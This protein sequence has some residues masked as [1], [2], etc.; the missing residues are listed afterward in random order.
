MTIKDKFP[1]VMIKELLD[2][3]RGAS[4]F[5]KLDMCSGYHQ[6]RMHPDD[7]DKTAFRTHPGLFEFLLYLIYNVLQ[8]QDPQLCVKKSRCEFGLMAL[9]YLGHIISAQGVAMDQLKVQAVLDW[10]QPSS[11]S[12]LRGFLSLACFNRRFIH[13]FGAIVAPLTALKDGFCWSEAAS[14]HSRLPSQHLWYCSS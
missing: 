6:V 2:E 11:I 10:P 9:P 12:T 3:L 13:N 8:P 14:W 5:T 1:I 4:F 7:I